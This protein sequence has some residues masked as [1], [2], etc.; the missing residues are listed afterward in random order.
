MVCTVPAHLVPPYI[1]ALCDDAVKAC[2]AASL[3]ISGNFRGKCAAGAAVEDLRL[4]QGGHDQQS[5]LQVQKVLL[6]T[7]HAEV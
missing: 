3:Q 2:D 6:M 7:P 1:S 5:R 4:R